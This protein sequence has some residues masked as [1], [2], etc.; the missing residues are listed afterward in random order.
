MENVTMKS[1]K[2]QIYD[3]YQEA[4]KQIKAKASL[5]ED[6]KQDQKNAEKAE[7]IAAAEQ[8]IDSGI[9][10]D[11]LVQQ[12]QSF[13]DRLQEL[14]TEAEETYGVI[15]EAESLA[16]MVNAHATKK[17]ELEQEFAAKKANLEAEYAE[18]AA[19]LKQQITDTKLLY[20]DIQKKLE[21]EQQEKREK[22]AVERQREEEEYAYNLK[23][24]RQKEQDAWE[25]QKAKQLAELADREDVVAGREHAI[26]AQEDYIT[27]METKI[28]VFPKELEAAAEEAATKKEKEL[29][30]KFSYEKMLYER[31][32]E[33]EIEKLSSELALVKDAL[34]AAQTKNAE[35]QDKLDDA[36][37]RMNKLAADTVKAN[38]AVRIVQSNSE[39]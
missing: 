33:N 3:A 9:L 29:N 16:A 38:G 24:Q 15:V 18:R 37:D 12:Y 35:L 34:A 19:D 4:L 8:L 27:D 32:K 5:T 17:Y 30:K 20:A 1:T 21:A 23:R 6:L 11:T 22:L 7:R 31:E 39:K 26:E 14:K 13:E 25:D 36:Y 28:S 2:Q 10:N